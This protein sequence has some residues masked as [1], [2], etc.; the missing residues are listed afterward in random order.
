MCPTCGH[1]Q[2]PGPY[3]AAARAVGR[4]GGGRRL[5]VVPHCRSTSRD[6]GG[7][8]VFTGHKVLGPSGIGV[9]WGRP[10][11]LAAMPRS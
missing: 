10:E 7:L 5:P 6:W 8:L 4:A 2:R 9:L 1:A 3:V 11:L